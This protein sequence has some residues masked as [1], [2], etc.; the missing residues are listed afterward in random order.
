MKEKMRKDFSLSNLT[1]LYTL[2]NLTSKIISFGIFFLYTYF[3][4]K[5]DLGTYDL[6][7]NTVAVV[8]PIVCIQM[9]DAIIRWL[10]DENDE[11][12]VKKIITN[13]LIITTINIIFFSIAYT[14]VIQFII[15]RNNYLIYILIVAQ[16]YFLI[17]HQMAR[18]LKKNSIYVNG[19]VIY[20]IVFSITVLISLI[21]FKLK[22]E[23]LLIANIISFSCTT[24]YI[25][26]K[27]NIIKY[28]KFNLFNK[29]ISKD[30]IIFSLP[31]IPNA[32]SWWV[33]AV[34]NRYII[35]Y[36]MDVKANGIFSVSLKI[37]SI[38]L[39][40]C[41]IFNMAW[42]EKS[43]K[44]FN[45][46]D[47][48]TYYTK[49]FN[50][51]IY[52]LSGIII[53]LISL[54]K[55]IVKLIIQQTYF[56]SW[57]YMSILYIAIGF[58]A[59]AN[60]LGIGYLASKETKKAFE[61]TFYGAV[62]TVVFSALLIPY[63]DLTGASVAILIGFLIMFITRVWQTKKYFEIKFSTKKTFILS[64]LILISLIISYIDNILIEALNIIYSITV[65]VVLN[66]SLISEQTTILLLKYKYRILKYF[67]G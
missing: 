49:T 25:C 33:I 24:L 18:G 20:S 26:A 63:A 3:L 58:Q 10:I 50:K 65:F 43:L 13:C 28:I 2:G 48:D 6:I 4:S 5:E 15:I 53:L 38:L 55:S 47:R 40:L 36:F 56:E 21:I 8:L 61:T 52:L 19:G 66:R 14:I 39:M 32:L 64:T 35:L 29:N 23:G 22:I 17:I 41:S 60:F 1:I 34:S 62:S 30:I 46:T 67:P 45:S 44:F 37:P 31:L 51:Y 9:Y 12:I 54:S 27:I 7:I 16:A 57:Q 11:I 59:L 42:T